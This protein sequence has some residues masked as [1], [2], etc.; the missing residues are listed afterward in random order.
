MRRQRQLGAELEQE[1]ITLAQLIED[2]WRLHAAPNLRPSTRES[3]LSLWHVHVHDRLGPREL[4]AISPKV[5]TRFRADLEQAGV[6]T[7]TVVKAM[8]LVQSL[9]AF[10]VVEGRLEYNPMASVR[11]P[12]YE[13]AREPHIFLPADVEAIRAGLNPLG[14]MLVSLLAYSGAR[15]EEALRLLWGGVGPEALR[16]DG[17]KTRRPRWTPLLAPLAE[18]LREWR[19][20]SGAG[21]RPATPV[22]PAHDGG[23]WER[24]DWRNWRRRSWGH[25]VTDE[26]TGERV[27]VAGQK[28]SAQLPAAPAGTRPRDLRSSY[29]TVQIYAGV[30]LTTIAKWAGTS[31]ATIDKHYA[32]VLANWDGRPVPAE[33]QIACAREA[34]RGGRA[35]DGGGAEGD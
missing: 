8:A 15:P 14:A 29:I 12:T 27:W 22:V 2:Y 3:Y 17:Q 21:R 4:R 13:R 30:P 19:L 6:G 11:K 33:V 31:A 34:R 32:G 5:L 26:R 7:A 16:F 1:D 24:D 20:R 28:G 18:D 35:V 23:P 25:Y 10:A 9:L